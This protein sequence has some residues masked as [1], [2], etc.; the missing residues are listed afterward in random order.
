MRLQREGASTTRRCVCKE[1]PCNA[2]DTIIE[3]FSDHQ[4]PGIAI[5]SLVK[6]SFE[7]RNLSLVGKGYHSEERMIVIYNSGDRIKFWGKR[8]TFWGGFWGSSLAAFS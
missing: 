1:K 2:I 7:V 6:A 5:K 8:C 3:T 4:A